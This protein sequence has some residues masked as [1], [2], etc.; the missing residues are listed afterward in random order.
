MKTTKA[1]R[2]RGFKKLCIYFFLYFPSSTLFKKS[3]RNAA[4][5][6][7]PQIILSVKLKVQ[8]SSLVVHY[9]NALPLSYITTGRLFKNKSYI[10]VIHL[11]SF[12]TVLFRCLMFIKGIRSYSTPVICITII[13]ISIMPEGPM[14]TRPQKKIYCIF[15][16]GG[17]ETPTRNSSGRLI[18]F[19]PSR[20]EG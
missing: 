3:L 13:N 1:T 11:Y 5:F 10:H 8:V 15:M 4:S 18:G 19:A 20:W 14:R 12:L 7:I 9:S 17:R 2:E 16:F 6:Y